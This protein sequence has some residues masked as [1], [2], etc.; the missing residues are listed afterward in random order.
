MFRHRVIFSTS[1]PPFILVEGRIE[2]KETIQK[3]L[4]KKHNKKIKIISKPSNKD[5]GLLNISSQNTKLS[6]K[7]R[8]EEIRDLSGIFKGMENLFLLKNKI[9]LIESYD[10]SHFSGQNAVAGGVDFNV[11]GSCKDMY[12]IYNI[13]KVNY[14]YYQRYY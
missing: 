4:S 9:K 7:A 8:R 5:L 3:A 2:N 12:R 14:S 13:S 1:C 11:E 10:V 6:L